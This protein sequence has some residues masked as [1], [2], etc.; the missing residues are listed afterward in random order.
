MK[1]IEFGEDQLHNLE[2]IAA[3][4]FSEPDDPRCF[5]YKRVLVRPRINWV[6]VA[7]HCLL[8]VLGAVGLSCCWRIWA[9]MV[10]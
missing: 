4:L 2:D 9:R 10:V 8:P 6:L 7:A 3:T 5:G 1:Q